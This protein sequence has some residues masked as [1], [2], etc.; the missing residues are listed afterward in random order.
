MALKKNSA[1]DGPSRQSAKPIVPIGIVSQRSG[2]SIETIRFYEKIGVLPKALR[3]ESGR[4]AYHEE[5]VAR[6]NFIRRARELGFSLDEVRGLLTLADGAGNACEQVQSLAQHHLNE[7]VTKIANLTALQTVLSALV[8]EC[9]QGN[10]VACP[11]IAALLDD[12]GRRI[13]PMRVGT[14]LNDSEIR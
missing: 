8:T 2:C 1:P 5:D 9:G 13:F 10:N 14:Q 11:L 3:T 7:I 6:V 4:R 12:R